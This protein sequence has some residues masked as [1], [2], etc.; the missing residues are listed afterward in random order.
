MDRISDERL[1]YFDP[2]PHHQDFPQ[3]PKVWPREIIAALERQGA[4]VRGCIGPWN[5][6][7]RPWRELTPG[8][9][10]WLMQLGDPAPVETQRERSFCRAAAS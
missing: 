5:H 9:L 7:G 1:G 3:R 10:V 2:R 4:S 8:S 6:S